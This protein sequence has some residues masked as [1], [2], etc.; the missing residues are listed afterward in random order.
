MRNNLKN[1]AGVRSNAEMSR[2]RQSLLKKV[3][4][5]VPL[6]V[7]HALL[8]MGVV[9]GPMT[10]AKWIGFGLNTQLCLAFF[11]ALVYCALELIILGRNER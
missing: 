10:L 5:Y 2:K 4:W 7:F 8:F 1:V 6:V 11:G 9:L 3:L